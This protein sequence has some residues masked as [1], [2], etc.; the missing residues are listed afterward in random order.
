MKTE[1]WEC[2]FC[3]N[4]EKWFDEHYA[5]IINNHTEEMGSL[6]DEAFKRSI[7]PV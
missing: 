3:S 4:R 6:N 5:H 2:P 7:A 1:I